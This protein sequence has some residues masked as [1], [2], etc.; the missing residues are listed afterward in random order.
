MPDKSTRGISNLPVAIP[1]V[2]DAP[3]VAASNVGTS[4]AYNNGAAT[5]TLASSTGGLPSS[6]SI[7]TTPTTTTTV[8][9][10]STTITGLSSATSYTITAT[11]SNVSATGPA[12]T[13]SSIT[14]TTVPQNPTI[15][16]PTVA[17]GQ[18][19]TGNAN[20]SVPFT[21]GATGGAAVSAY[22][23][24]SSSGNTGTGASSPVAVSDTVGVART[25]TVTATNA[26][27][28]ST[29]SDASAATTPLSVPQA[30]TIGTATAGT[31][32][33]T[34][35]NVPFTAG[36][37]GGSSI[38]GYTVT[39]SPGSI[40]GT[41]SSSPITVSGL[42]PS[43]AYTFTVT[44]TNSQGTSASS[45]SSNSITTAAPT[46]YWAVNLN[47]DSAGNGFG[48]VSNSSNIVV[49][50]VSY[51]ATTLGTGVVVYDAD[52][53][54][55]WQRK[56]LVGGSYNPYGNVGLD[57][58]SNVYIT[59]ASDQGGNYGVN[60]A[61]FNSSGTTQWQR[62]L[63]G[64]TV[65]GFLSTNNIAFDS[66]YSVYLAGIFYNDPYDGIY[67][68]NLYKYNSSGTIQWQRGYRYSSD[69]CNA[70]TVFCDDT[71]NV[72]YLGSQS[73]GSFPGAYLS[74]WNTS[75][76]L[77]WGR[78]I[79]T[80]S[81]PLKSVVTDSSGNVYAALNGTNSGGTEGA[82]LMKYNSSGVLQWQ[83]L[84]SSNIYSTSLQQFLG[85]DSSNNIYMAHSDDSQNI[86]YVSKFDSSG[87][88][89]WNRQFTGVTG[90][91]VNGFTVGSDY[92]EVAFYASSGA[93]YPA[94]SM[95]FK[96]P[97]DGTKTGTKTVNGMSV[98][99]GNATTLT[100]STANNSDASSNLTSSTL[101]RTDSAGSYT[102]STPT[103]TRSIVSY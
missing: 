38:T 14:A 15:G 100:I 43:T 96:L 102:I 10:G 26:N 47:R 71:N 44:A 30:P 37:T 53:A 83:K 35:V 27:G 28:T 93:T 19:Y 84:A 45:S 59:S 57:K 63:V 54:L 22:T 49:N 90:A 39:S 3:T 4:R 81:T 86:A 65:G 103:D 23:V 89:V 87:N 72:V 31:T 78:R 33:S 52:G 76:T 98:V 92:F 51:N 42:S 95:I 5:V 12:G 29:A 17:T 32:P 46:T 60:I 88:S 2:P 101:S 91:R 24:T 16:S 6:Y 7:T 58:A 70:N 13:S 20:V 61:K 97:L 77:Q 40:T 55:L 34:Q 69:S 8:A 50:A 1:D 75:G 48:V 9:T 64:S 79:R 25:Y 85:V 62:F 73:A 99:Y 74:A 36:A 82:T 41:G 66:S 18:A 21:A 11:P 94:T 68:L 80:V 56:G 67:F